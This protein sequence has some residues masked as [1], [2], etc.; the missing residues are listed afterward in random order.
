MN[1]G[2]SIRNERI[3]IHSVYPENGMLSWICRLAVLPGR[4]HE[5]W[6][7]CSC[8]HCALP[9]QNLFVVR[10]LLGDGIQESRSVAA[11]F[12]T[13]IHKRE[14]VEENKRP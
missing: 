8:T 6:A 5:A 14:L 11:V 12:L 3:C 9:G 13:A 2:G 1:H 4:R 7:T 10:D